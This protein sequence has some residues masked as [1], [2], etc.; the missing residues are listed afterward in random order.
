MLLPYAQ[1][2]PGLFWLSAAVYTPIHE[3]SGT[4]FFSEWDYYGYIDNTTWG[5]PQCAGT[6]HTSGTSQG[7]TY[8]DIN[9]GHAIIK[10]D[11]TTNI[12]AA[13]TVNR[14]S[15]KITSK[16]AYPISS[17]VVIDVSHTWSKL[18]H[19]NG[20]LDGSRMLGTR[21][22]TK[23]LWKRFRTSGWRCFRYAARC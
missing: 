21:N 2:L 10:V 17:L 13:P 23:Q 7:L 22:K 8:I 16:D 11:N 15:V 18:Y 6:L 19:R 12:A 5:E 20:L 3:Y 14:N 9:T 4:D 1:L